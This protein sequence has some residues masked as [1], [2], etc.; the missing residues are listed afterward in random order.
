LTNSKI[1][2]GSKISNHF[3]VEPLKS[4]SEFGSTIDCLLL[5]LA[6]D[7]S[8]ADEFNSFL[9]NH[10]RS[11]NVLEN[12]VPRDQLNNTCR[13]LVGSGK[14][15]RI[16]GLLEGELEKEGRS[17][18]TWVFE[19]LSSLAESSLES[20]DLDRCLGILL[21][22]AAVHPKSAT[23]IVLS[24]LLHQQLTQEQQ[25]QTTEILEVLSTSE[26]GCLNLLQHSSAVLQLASNGLL[27]LRQL[28]ALPQRWIETVPEFNNRGLC[29]ALVQALIVVPQL[30]LDESLLTS[31]VLPGLA[32][33]LQLL[34]NPGFRTFS[35][36]PSPSSSTSATA[37]TSTSAGMASSAVATTAPAIA[38]TS[39][40]GAITSPSADIGELE[41]AVLMLMSEVE[42]ARR[43]NST[44]FLQQQQQHHLQHEGDLEQQQTPQNQACSQ[45]KSESLK[46]RERMQKLFSKPG[47]ATP[48]RNIFKK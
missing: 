30:N 20:R 25:G 40:T 7:G 28:C 29:V 3:L 47:T 12:A 13:L 5:F 32:Q 21:K 2:L 8:S 24:I 11:L 44:S 43:R 26:P 38:M 10:L 33:M 42:G 22:E 27:L 6:E 48:R 16:I 46:V 36:S 34:Q 1:F 31:C 9:T 35:P 41:T 23:S 15:G 37:L 14:T 45:E 4:K 39:P 17:R 18:E 19:L